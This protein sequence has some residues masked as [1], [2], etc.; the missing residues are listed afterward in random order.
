MDKVKNSLLACLIFATAGTV[1][2]AESVN[3]S[4][5]V[6]RHEITWTFD[7][8]YPT[9]SFV[10]GDPWV[11][12][13]V[14]IVSVTPGWDG[15]VNGTQVDPPIAGKE[16]QGFRKDYKFGAPYRDDLLA[17]FPLSLRGTRSVVS[18]IGMKP[19]R[20]GG[21]YEAFES[22]SVLTVVDEVPPRDAFRPPYIKGSK[23]FYAVSQIQWNRLPSL[24][25]P[26]GFVAPKKNPMVRLWMDHNGTRGNANGTIHPRRNMAPYYFFM[27]VSRM[28]VTLLVDFPRR[29]E[30][31]YSF[32][33]YGIDC[34]HISLN[35][36]DAW[37]AYGGFGNGRKWPILFTGILLDDEKMI[38][39]LKTCKTTWARTDTV[40]KFG[41]DGH[42]YHGK[43]TK[44]YPRG[45]PLW[46]QDA[47][48]GR[49]FRNHDNRD[50]NGI[51]EPMQ[52]PK[53][54]PI[55]GS[56]RFIC[57]RGW[58]GQA[59]AARL[60][61]AMDLWD[62]PA[63][64]DYVDRWIREEAPKKQ[65]DYYSYGPDPI[66]AMWLKYRPEADEIGKKYLRAQSNPE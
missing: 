5:E 16:G 6:S 20:R 3:K 41:E 60:M 51:L 12:G 14:K 48:P 44:G 62:H 61:G 65:K 38:H 50:P 43:P 25:A 29:K 4:D 18:T 10:N 22:A 37:R 56:Y 30:L 17:K 63:F 39:P 28:S 24:E 8:D 13:P 34:Y 26:E 45:K 15:E 46:G 23:P 21:A 42:T 1:S 66:K 11:L 47:P 54:N 31:L 64:F 58:P 32:M 57:S 27:D 52:L 35:N 53:D 2:V 59:L 19:Q 33:Q 7:T 9:G 49:W 55:G 36:G 40:D